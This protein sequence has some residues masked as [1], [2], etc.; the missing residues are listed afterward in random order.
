MDNFVNSVSNTTKGGKP[1]LNAPLSANSAALIPVTA[2]MSKSA[3]QIKFSGQTYLIK[4]AAPL[5]AQQFTKAHAFL[6]NIVQQNSLAT[7]ASQMQ[8]LTLGQSVFFPMPKAM[9]A[10]AK[11]NNISEQKLLNL[12]RKAEGYLLPIAKSHGTELQFNNGANIR[13]PML[14]ALADGEYSVAI[15]TKGQQ[16]FLKL[17]PIQAQIPI[18]FDGQLGHNS[19]Q[20]STGDLQQPVAQI[21]KA[22]TNVNYEYKQ[23]FSS[24]ENMSLPGSINSSAVAAKSALAVTSTASPK[25]AGQQSFLASALAKAGGLPRA[26]I[27]YSSPLTSL[28][29]ALFKILPQ[30][31]PESMSSLSEPKRLQQALLSLITLNIAPTTWTT[32][33]NSHID[34]LSLLCQLMLGR[35]AAKQSLSPELHNRLALLQAKLGLSP[36]LLSL[37]EATGAQTSM[38]SLLNNLSLYQQQSGTLDGVNHWY[39]ALPYSIN[40]YQEQFEGHFE[41]VEE[42]SKTS[43]KWKLR[44]KFNLSSGPLLIT[45]TANVAGSAEDPLLLSVNFTSDSETLLSKV[46]LLSPSLVSKVEQLGITIS[47]INTQQQTVAATLLPGEHYLV[48]VEV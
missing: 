13:L 39:F 38:T 25:Q 48:K 2:T 24:L 19:L 3:T 29:S 4:L 32:T 33:A 15:K 43:E 6:L 21:D 41:Q 34:S 36:Q 30:L 11:R 31:S 17:S 46:R 10:L 37:L 35:A 45:A 44:L 7:S 26:S 40:H 9:L 1:A 8:L 20:H 18:S 5:A 22:K 16:L 23:L 42:Q 12:A 28:A 47:N 27:K 14:A